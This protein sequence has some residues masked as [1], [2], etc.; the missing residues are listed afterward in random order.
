M[1][2]VASLIFFRGGRSPLGV[3]R[4]NDTSIVPTEL[5]TMPETAE[6]HNDLCCDAAL[7]IPQRAHGGTYCSERRR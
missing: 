7:R 4:Q 3:Q 6:V 2:Y 5:C 1:S